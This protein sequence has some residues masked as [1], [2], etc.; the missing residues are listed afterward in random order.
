M[1]NRLIAGSSAQWMLPG[2]KPSSRRSWKAFRGNLMHSWRSKRHP[3]SLSMHHPSTNPSSYFTHVANGILFL[4]DCN[5]SVLFGNQ[6]S[7]HFRHK[8]MSFYACFFL[9]NQKVELRKILVDLSKEDVQLNQVVTRCRPYQLHAI[10]KQS[11]PH[12]APSTLLC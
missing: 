8:T 7:L 10:P 9:R 4:S 12:V 11:F 5:F 2:W 3:S 6:Y 1:P